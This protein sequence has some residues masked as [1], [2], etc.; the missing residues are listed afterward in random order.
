MFYF[1]NSNDLTLKLIQNC[2]KDKE[3]FEILANFICNYFYVNIF[4]S[5]FLNESLLTLIYL[6]LEKEIDLLTNEKSS[7]NFLDSSKSFTAVLFKHLS[8]RDEV[9]TYLENVLKKLLISTAG[10]LPNQKN[11][12]FIGFDINKI[13]SLL[14]KVKYPLPK[15]QKMKETLNEILTTDIKKS[16]LNMDFLNN[17]K[18]NKEKKV[19]NEDEDDIELTK[20]EIENN[21]YVQATKETFDD[22]LLGNEEDDEERKMLNDE[23]DENSNQKKNNFFGGNSGHKKKR[24]GKDDIE[25]FLINS[26]FYNRPIV[27]GQNEEEKR[28]EEEEMKRKEE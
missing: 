14:T 10:L 24:E 17:N 7:Y 22:L 16:R 19:K 25:N 3:S 2:P 8:R 1:R 21:F 9:K 26:G 15:T 18:T 23:D 28:R 27:K 11:K 13:K 12:M 20:E 5:T 4:S 6:L